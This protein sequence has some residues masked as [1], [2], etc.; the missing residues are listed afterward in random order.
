MARK[1]ATTSE[2]KIDAMLSDESELEVQAEV[3]SGESFEIPAPP[4]PPVKEIKKAKKQEHPKF[5]KFK[6][7]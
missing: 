4:A 3:E 1:K 2:E 6:K 7:G 5:A